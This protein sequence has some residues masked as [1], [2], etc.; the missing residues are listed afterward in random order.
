[1]SARHNLLILLGLVLF[2]PVMAACS[3]GPFAAGEAPT[4]AGDGTM[5][6]LEAGGQGPAVAATEV[7][8]SPTPETP[9]TGEG[10]W[11]V[12]F[13]TADGVTLHGTLHGESTQG[14]VL[15]PMY[16]GEQA[17]WKPFQEALASQGY[18]ALAFDFR[19]HG[20]S[21]GERSASTAP[22]DLA[23]AV[24]FMR[25]H[26][27][28]QIV[29]AGAGLGGMAG[30]QLAAQDGGITGLVVISSPRSL[31]DLEV[32]DGDL[33]ALTLPTLWL[34]ARN[35][36]SQHVEEMYELAASSDKA[37]WI[38]EGSSLPGTFI[39]EGADGPDLERRLL[40][41]VTRVFGS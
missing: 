29:L 13:Q 23:A 39:F 38:Y 27:V 40:E 25:E 36:M 20:A 11:E 15:A 8:P 17:G 32:T 37:L 12:T 33:A 4:P 21:E 14:V 26:D 35:D 16:P 19:G 10:P 22:V 41:F 7:L 18:R 6:T 30:I 5:P 2:L 1:M 3:A 28:E 31:E 24:A 34:G 9:L